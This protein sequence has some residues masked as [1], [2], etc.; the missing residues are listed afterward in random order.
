MLEQQG[1]IEFPPPPGGD[2]SRPL[3]CCLRCTANPAAHVASAGKFE[4]R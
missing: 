3:Y 1:L 4:V 2:V